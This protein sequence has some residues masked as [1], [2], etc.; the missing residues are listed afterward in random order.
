MKTGIVGVLNNPATSDNS[1]SAGMVNIV[2]ELFNASV[3]KESDNWNE[4]DRLIVY[5]GVNFRQGTFNVIG[6]I[7][8]DVLLRAKKLN[9][10]KLE[11][12]TL[13]GFQLNEFS[14]VRKINL[15]DNCDNIQKI[16]LPKRNNLVIG[17]SHSLSVWPNSNYEISRNDGKTLHGFLKLNMDLSNYNHIIMYF[18]NIDIRFHLA[19]QNEPIK[20]TKDLFNKYC[21]YASKYN[22]TLT[23][24]LPIEDESRKIPKSGQYKGQNFF[25]SIELRKELRLEANRIILESGLDY[26]EWPSTF[27]NSDG[28]LSFEVMEPKQSVHIRPKFYLKNIKKQLTLF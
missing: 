3:L 7:N 28:N 22:S 4:Y 15:F 23:M 6:G 8:N 1:H 19:R 17:D 26:L 20:A 9:D 5:H 25:G 2:K 24:L 16:E 12:Y 13:D 21:D 18:G 27:L 11:K 10:F 14:K